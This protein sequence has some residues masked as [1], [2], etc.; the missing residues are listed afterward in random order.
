[1]LQF[2]FSRVAK[3]ERNRNRLKYGGRNTERLLFLHT[4]R[5]ATVGRAQAKAKFPA[6]LW[7]ECLSV[8]QNRWPSNALRGGISGMVRPV[9][10]A[11]RP[12]QNSHD[13]SSIQP[14]SA[15]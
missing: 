15:L 12:R 9:A 11:K 14:G 3:T 1:M 10:R 5:I 2:L 8:A 6:E 13:R 7:E 4:T